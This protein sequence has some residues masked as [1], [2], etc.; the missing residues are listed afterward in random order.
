MNEYT[1]DPV[2]RNIRKKSSPFWLCK[3]LVRNETARRSVAGEAEPMALWIGGQ[4]QQRCSR[5]TLTGASRPSSRKG[6]VDYVVA[7]TT[8]DLVVKEFLDVLDGP[9]DGD[10]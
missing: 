4:R 10:C 1:R 9:R 3:L 7:S 8:V 2:K 6:Q 5:E